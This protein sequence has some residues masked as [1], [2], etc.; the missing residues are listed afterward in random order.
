MSDGIPNKPNQQGNNSGY[1]GMDLGKLIDKRSKKTITHPYR[2]ALPKR[3]DYFLW[4]HT[5]S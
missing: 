2:R 4:A 5:L 3:T 1:G